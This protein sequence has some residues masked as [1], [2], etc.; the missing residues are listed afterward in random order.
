MDISGA[1][2]IIR[3]IIG[4]TY[5]PFLVN[6]GLAYWVIVVFRRIAGV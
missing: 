4:E 1:L 3:L 2:V 5:L 6:F